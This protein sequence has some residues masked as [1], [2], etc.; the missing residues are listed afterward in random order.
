MAKKLLD[1]AGTSILFIGMFLAFLPHAL[2][3][4]AGLDESASHVE[5]VIYGLF[6]V[7]IGLGILVFNNKALKNQRFLGTKNVKRF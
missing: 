6:L 2:H 1:I 7:V 4:R 5:H 3:L